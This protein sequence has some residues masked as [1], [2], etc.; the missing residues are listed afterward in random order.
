MQ[1]NNFYYITNNKHFTKIKE[2]NSSLEAN[3]D[4]C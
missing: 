3:L 4:M 2:Q 1:N